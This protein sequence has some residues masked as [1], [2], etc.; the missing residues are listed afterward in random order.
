MTTSITTGKLLVDYET[1]RVLRADDET[2]VTPRFVESHPFIEHR[3][4][5]GD[6]VIFAGPDA[7][8][9]MAARVN[10][11]GERHLDAVEY[12]LNQNGSPQWLLR[13]KEDA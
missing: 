6:I 2:E 8:R 3:A 13:K 7:R 5:R 12:E 1:G 11:E 10:G 4:I 9:R